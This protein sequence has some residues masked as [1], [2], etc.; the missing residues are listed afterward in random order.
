MCPGAPGAHCSLH[1][2]LGVFQL[3][4]MGEPPTTT[5]TSH[6]PRTRAGRT[7]GSLDFWAWI[8]Q[9]NEGI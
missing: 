5:C 9:G 2:A 1:N 7:G 4:H 3:S 8:L 6:T